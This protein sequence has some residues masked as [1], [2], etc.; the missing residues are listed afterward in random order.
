[1]NM[2]LQEYK[3][4][5]TFSAMSAEKCNPLAFFGA[6]GEYY[7]ENPQDP[8]AEIAEF[9]KNDSGIIKLLILPPC[10]QKTLNF[11][12]QNFPKLKKI[13]VTDCDSL[14]FEQWQQNYD[15][16]GE[17]IEAVSF[18][19][20]E[21][22]LS[23]CSEILERGAARVYIPARYKR[24]EKKFS[25]KLVEDVL[26]IQQKLC[27]RLAHQTL[28]NWHK[29]LNRFIN[30]DSDVN[31]PEYSK[32]AGKTVVIAGAGPSLKKDLENIIEYKELFYFIVTDGAL[33][34]FE[35]LQIIPEVIV[36]SEDCLQSWRFFA[37][38]NPQFAEC[39]LFTPFSENHMIVEHF[40][41]QHFFTKS[42]SDDE[43]IFDGLCGDIPKVELGS[44]VGHYAFYLA[45][46]FCPDKIVMVGF[47]LS[48]LHG[49]FHP[50]EMPIKYFENQEMPNPVIIKDKNGRDLQTDLSMKMY[51]EGFEQMI[52]NSANKV[53]NLTE[54]GAFIEGALFAESAKIFADSA[55]IENLRVCIQEEQAR[56]VKMHEKI[57]L[58]YKNDLWQ[59][60]KMKS[61]LSQVILNSL[62]DSMRAKISHGT[63]VD[64]EKK[65]LESFYD[66]FDVLNRLR[67]R[68]QKEINN[69]L[70]MIP[71]EGFFQEEFLK[72]VLEEKFKNVFMLPETTGL[73]DIWECVL[74][75]S[76]STICLI[77]GNVIP[78]VFAATKLQCIDFKTEFSP[79]LNEK[80]FWVGGYSLL[81]ENE[82]VE[83]WQDFLDNDI[84]IEKVKKN[85]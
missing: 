72:D 33:K 58:D 12:L 15:C 42:E 39:A 73:S 16:L 78:D 19:F 31:V 23:A 55:K 37:S 27:S 24:F 4:I 57:E 75:K 46:N 13:I 85:V 9:F 48:F 38:L 59:N 74:R 29:N 1:M 3:K 45:E 82:H 51:L 22:T 60:L 67:C 34:T 71:K 62:P 49:K 77:N 69:C 44:C 18:D 50:E 56:T 81:V 28:R 54:D 40:I 80:H 11:V 21:S 47:N 25:Q 53:F 41:G 70:L 7:I 63:L 36:S 10:S 20:F 5:A 32:F 17:R 79:S 61:F 52:A 30:F 66:F 6:K 26:T 84:K 2:E 64:I 65:E 43:W 14:R 76:I 35:S 68:N 83:Q 8:I